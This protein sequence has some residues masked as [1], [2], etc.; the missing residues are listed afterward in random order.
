M[1]KIIIVFLTIFLF[2]FLSLYADEI[3]NL[4]GETK[5]A[6]EVK[7]ENK[8]REGLVTGVKGQVFVKYD[9][10]K[11]WKQLLK[12]DKIR[13]KGTIITMEDSEITIKL[14]DDSNATI[15]QK[16]RAYMTTLRV[17]PKIEAINETEIKLMVGKVYSNIKKSLENGSRYEVKT[18]SATAGVRGTQFSVWADSVGN[19]GVNVF[20]GTVAFSNNLDGKIFFIKQNEKMIIDN[21]GGNKNIEQNDEKPPQE[22]VEEEKKEDGNT[23]NKDNTAGNKEEIKKEPAKELPPVKEIVIIDDKWIEDNFETILNEREILPINNIDSKA[24]EI[25]KER[26]ST[27]TLEINIR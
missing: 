26:E 2:G 17:N 14:T 25:I 27:G 13:E 15:L 10:D 23:E 8:Q 18:G 22:L 4:L 16:S 19:S 5:K 11:I 7:T 1:K 6:K 21:K 24:L 12:G 9:G 3:E 20:K